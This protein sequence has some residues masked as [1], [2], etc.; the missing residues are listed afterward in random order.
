MTRQGARQAGPQRQVARLLPRPR[1]E[2]AAG[3]GLLG[4]SASAVHSTD[5]VLKKHAGA[6]QP[7]HAGPTAGTGP[8]A[9]SLTA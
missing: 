4:R 5:A 2:L 3:P 6:A 7:V 8:T 9:A 1:A